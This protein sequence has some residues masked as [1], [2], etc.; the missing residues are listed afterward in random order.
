[1]DVSQLKNSTVVRIVRC[2]ELVVPF[3]R[4]CK[5]VTFY[6]LL[7]FRYGKSAMASRTR[8]V[9]HFIQTHSF[10]HTHTQFLLESKIIRFLCKSC[11]VA[12]IC[13][14]CFSVAEL[15]QMLH[16]ML[17]AASQIMCCNTRGN[18]LALNPGT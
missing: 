5:G 18:C 1:M 4:Y 16:W 3:D 15:V 10:R 12:M 2:E 13:V 8:L 6:F 14:M 9:L 17:M 7:H 11:T